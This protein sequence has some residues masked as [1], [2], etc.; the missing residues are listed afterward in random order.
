MGQYLEQ[1][2]RARETTTEV[3]PGGLATL[4]FG[5]DEYLGSETFHACGPFV[6]P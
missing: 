1:V 4:A 5:R 2:T 3:K 6:K